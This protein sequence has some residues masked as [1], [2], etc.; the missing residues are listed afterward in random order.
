MALYRFEAR[1]IGRE[2]RGYSVVAASAYRAGI[3]LHDER[4]GKT[5]D[6]SRRSKG[7][8]TSTVL[9]PQGAPEWVSDPESLWNRVEAGEKRKDSQLAREF[10]L[11]LPKE[12]SREEQFRL[13]VE[14][15]QERLVGPGLVAQVAIHYTKSGKNPHAHVLC[16]MRKLDG[17][18]FHAKKATEWNKRQVLRELRESWADAVNAALEKAGR[19]ERVDH[20]S[21]KEQ[22]IDRMPQPKVGVATTAMKLKGLLQ[23]PERFKLLRWVKSLNEVRPHLRAIQKEGEVSQIGLGE[24]WWEKSVLLLQAARHKTRETVVDTWRKLIGSPAPKGPDMA[25]HQ[26]GPDMSR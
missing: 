17:E 22:G 25:P 8:V 18:K 26:R 21:L 13:T 15:A 16:T 1:I 19:P 12:L 20:R 7:V 24:T 10:I 3:K 14:W 9:T 11:S 6:Y 2:S 5:H 23:D 4:N